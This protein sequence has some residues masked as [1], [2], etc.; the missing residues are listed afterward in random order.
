M[1]TT[2]A[3]ILFAAL[4]IGIGLQVYL[5]RRKN[6]KEARNSQ[7]LD[8]EQAELDIENEDTDLPPVKTITVGT[9]LSSDIN[10]EVNGICKSFNHHKVVNDVSFTLNR[11]E[12]FGMVGPN[13][14]GKTTAIRMIMDILKPD[15]GDV[16]ILGQKFNDDVKEKIGYLPEE[17]GMYKKL[18]VMESLTYMAALKGVEANPARSHAIDLLEKVGM[19]Q[20]RDKKVEE[21]SRGMS[22][23]VQFLITIQHDPEIVVLDE[24]FANLDPVNTRLLKDMVIEMRNKG[25]AIILST[26]LMNEVEEMCD[27]ILMIHRGR[28]MLY[29]NLKDIKE[30]YRENSVFVQC[31]N[32]P[33]QIAGVIKTR[34]H[35]GYS[36]LFLTEDTKPQEVL[37]AL[38]NEGVRVDRFENA[39]PSLNDIFI[40]VVEEAKR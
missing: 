4:A 20:H 29:G 35:S 30:K 7:K 11:G 34:Q 33:G 10:L 27:R 38:V 2:T 24:P 1:D 12:I 15:S 31:D 8:P 21:L 9:V 32:L 14:A 36:E 40:Q 18:T 13:G 5:R 37:N 22:Q 23:I 26:H 17:R 6:K 25:T 28:A 3:I 39:M 16:V 19:G